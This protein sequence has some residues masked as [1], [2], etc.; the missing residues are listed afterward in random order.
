MDISSIFDIIL[1]KH[2]EKE[3]AEVFNK[4]L[5]QMQTEL[6]NKFIHELKSTAYSLDFNEANTIIDESGTID[7]DILAEST[8]KSNAK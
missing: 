1:S 7:I 3:M 8:K 4:Y 5:P 2:R 6:K